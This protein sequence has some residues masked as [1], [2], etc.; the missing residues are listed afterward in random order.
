MVIFSPLRLL[1]LIDSRGIFLHP[2]QR[3]KL[4]Y[5]EIKGG[6]NLSITFEIWDSSVGLPGLEPRSKKSFHIVT[7]I[8][9]EFKPFYTVTLTR[10]LNRLT[11]LFSMIFDSPGKH[12]ISVPIDA[13]EDATFVLSMITEH[14]L[15]YEDSFNVQISSKFYVW[16]KYMVLSPVIVFCTPLILRTLKTKQ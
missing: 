5:M 10:G 12:T 1:F 4:K 9:D 14:G 13:P 6:Q 2:A 16:I 3:E 8:V 7:D 11:P 15:Y